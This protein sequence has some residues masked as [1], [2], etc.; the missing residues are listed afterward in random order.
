[1]PYATNTD[2]V[3]EFVALAQSGGFLNDGSTKVRAD[4]VD[5]WCTRASNL[6]DSYIGGKYHV[7]V[8][9]DA[10][11]NSYN[12]LKEIVCWIVFPRVKSVIGAA[13]GDSKSATGQGSDKTDYRKEALDKL[14]LIQKGTLKLNDAVLA[15]PADGVGSHA[16]SGP[17]N[18]PRLEFR[19]GRRNW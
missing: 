18:P 6:A 13:T 9:P 11:P 4:Q 16:T 14:I 12:L 5:E 1:M 2:L 10:S 19:R 3:A 7:P 15:T 8:D 17:C